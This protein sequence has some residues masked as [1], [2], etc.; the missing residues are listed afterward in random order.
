KPAATLLNS[1]DSVIRYEFHF[2][3]HLPR[4]YHLSNGSAQKMIL[5]LALVS[6][7]H[8][9]R[10]SRPSPWPDS[11]FCRPLRLSDQ[12][13]RTE[14]QSAGV[15]R[16]ATELGGPHGEMRFVHYSR[17]FRNQVC[18]PAKEPSALNRK[19]TIVCAARHR[20]ARRAVHTGP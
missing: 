19:D 4:I 17:C 5:T 12:S 13:G 18:V 1:T 20:E 2:S 14:S 3:C 9:W 6:G 10:R 8:D 16:G 15:S 7:N 11:S